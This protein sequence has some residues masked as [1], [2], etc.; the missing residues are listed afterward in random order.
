MD[1]TLASNAS[2]QGSLLPS[3]LCVLLSSKPRPYVNRYMYYRA[4][5]THLYQQIYLGLVYYVV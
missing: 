4:H 5:L 3:P 2:A 1:G